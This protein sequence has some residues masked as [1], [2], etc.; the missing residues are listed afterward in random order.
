[1]TFLEQ[2]LI[3]FHQRVPSTQ[4][5]KMRGRRLYWYTLVS[6]GLAVSGNVVIVVV[7]E[8][9]HDLQV[10]LQVIGV[11]LCTWLRISKVV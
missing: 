8:T 2:L 3:T 6:A 1:M 5:R 9:K 10:H 11:S 7:L 4:T